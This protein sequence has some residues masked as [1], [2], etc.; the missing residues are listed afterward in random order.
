MNRRQK[1]TIYLFIT[2]VVISFY[3]FG[4][5]MMDYFMVYPSRFLVGENEFIAY[6]QLL[7][8]AIWPISVVPFLVII[9]LNFFMLKF[10]PQGVPSRLVF[11]S[12]TCLVLDFLSTVMLQAPWNYELLWQGKN[13]ALMQKIS[14]TNWL[15]VFL[16]SLQVL[17]AFTMLK[18][19]VFP[20]AERSH[21]NHPV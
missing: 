2:F 19:F 10:R 4:T 13:V 20:L 5:A 12:L 18:S 8:K 7:E 17:F 1:F 9:I 11:Y 16:E 3:S 14:D 15:R 6:H 21:A